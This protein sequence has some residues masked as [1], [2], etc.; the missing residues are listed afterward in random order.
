MADST[1]TN[2]SERSDPAAPDADPIAL[3]VP[4]Y[5]I[6][7]ELAH[8]GLGRVLRQSLKPHARSLRL[9]DI[10]A[11]QPAGPGEEVVPC[12][13]ADKAAVDALVKGCDAIVHL[14]R[15]PDGSRRVSEIAV[16]SSRRHEEFRLHRLLEFAALPMNPDRSVGGRFRHHPLPRHIAA[17]I[18]NVGENIP[19]VF[20]VVPDTRPQGS[21]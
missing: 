5:R 15:W 7:R 17:R 2:P 4:H 16:V 18:Y 9:S 1:L 14:G 11:M 12:D 8:G 20:G 10:A 6:E 13:L 21:P 19:S 3:T